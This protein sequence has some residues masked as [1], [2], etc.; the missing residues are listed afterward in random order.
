MMQAWADHLD[1]LR[2]APNEQTSAALFS[3]FAPTHVAPEH[4]IEQTTLL[5]ATGTISPSSGRRPLSS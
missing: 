4:L 2:L 1:G 3:R 5:R